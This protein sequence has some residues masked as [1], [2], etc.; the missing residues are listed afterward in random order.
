MFS[1]HNE[2]KL[3]VNNLKISEKI[4]N[5]GRLNNTHLNITWVKEEFSRE[6]KNILK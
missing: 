5:I 3:K 4:P 6:I 2:I 1:D